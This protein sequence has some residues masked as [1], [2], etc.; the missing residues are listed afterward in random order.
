MQWRRS[1]NLATQKKK[2]GR[3]TTPAKTEQVNNS[4]D[5]SLGAMVVGYGFIALSAIALLSCISVV[6]VGSEKG[7]MTLLK[8]FRRADVK[9]PLYIVGAGPQENEIRQYIQ[10]HKMQE[11][12]KMLMM[13]EI[14]GYTYFQLT[15]I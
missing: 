10:Q 5:R 13:K 12:V 6:Y 15:M 11:T 2:T 3:K 4:G 8:A 7:I 9:K 14:N 1:F